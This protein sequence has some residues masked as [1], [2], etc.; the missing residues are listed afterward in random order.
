M[1]QILSTMS[2]VYEVLN[3]TNG[4]WLDAS[5]PLYNQPRVRGLKSHQR[6]LVDVSNPLYTE[7][8]LP[9]KFLTLRILDL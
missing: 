8:L 1:L 5:D 4:S 3:P 7:S 2:H 6:E 9:V